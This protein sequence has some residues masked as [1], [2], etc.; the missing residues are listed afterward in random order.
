MPVTDIDLFQI[1]KGKLGEDETKSLIEFVETRSK[2]SEN[3]VR[4]EW[5]SDKKTLATKDDVSKVETTLI[6]TESFLKQD[7]ARLEINLKQDISK[8]ESRME[9]AFK[10]Q[11]KWL[12]ILL[13]GFSSLIIT[14]IKLL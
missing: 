6:K 3:E 10:D 12:I 14:V 4:Q 13:F 2:S 1:L 9:A 7:L 8:L 11:L 5:V